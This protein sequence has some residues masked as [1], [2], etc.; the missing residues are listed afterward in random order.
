MY[1]VGLGKWENGCNPLDSS[2]QLSNNVIGGPVQVGGGRQS[3]KQSD[4]VPV[5][6]YLLVLKQLQ[7]PTPLIAIYRVGTTSLSR[8]R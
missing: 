4:A 7:Q 5:P 6:V 8:G 1:K 3:N 2:T